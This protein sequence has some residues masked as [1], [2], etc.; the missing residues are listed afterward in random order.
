MCFAETTNL[1]PG[2]EDMISTIV[3]NCLICTITAHKRIRT[4]IGAQRSSYYAPSQCLVIDSAY[5]PRSQYGY[6]KALIL[7]DACTGYVIVYPSTNLLTVTVRK[8]LLTDLSSHPIPAEIKADFGPEFQQDLDQLLA[9]YSIELSGSK[10]FS[11]GSTSNAESAIKLV[12]GAMRQMC[13]SHTAN[14]PQLVPILVQGLNSQGL[15]GTSTSRNQLYFSPYSY[16]NLLRLNSLL[17]PEC[18]FNENY[19]K[20]NFIIKRRQSRLT[21]KQ[22]LDK[23]KYQPGNIVFATNHPVKSDGTSQELAMTVKG[24]IT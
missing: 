13:L 22:V 19:E 11:T 16:P 2:L 5:L 15:Y 21:K 17:F 9:K 18:I 14:W 20:L 4:L 12:K 6:S 7:V 1:P 24:I 23:T 10:P 8:H 3:K